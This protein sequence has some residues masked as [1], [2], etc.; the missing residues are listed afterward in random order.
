M[1]RKPEAVNLAL[2]EFR[3]YLETLTC[4]QI[5][6]R[7][8]GQ[9]RQSDIVQNTLVEA[10]KQ[11]DSLLMLDDAARKRRLR[12]MLINNLLDRVR[13]VTAACRDAR[14]EL[15]LEESAYRLKGQLIAEDRSPIE[16][17]EQAEEK[18]LLRERVLEALAQLPERERDALILQKYHD[19]TLAQIAE[20][21]GCTAGAVAGLHARGLKRLRQLLPD[22]E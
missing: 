7:L 2:E 18:E 8:R 21:L 16:Q 14:L 10:W 5:D 3:A 12:R 4:I 19:W 17:V 20:H 6:P 15:S 13:E 22:M 1:L 9:V 11:L